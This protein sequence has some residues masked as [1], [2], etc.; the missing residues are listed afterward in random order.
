MLAH[1]SAAGIEV[2]APAKINL[3]LEVIARRQDGY[4]EIETVLAPISLYDTLV[5]R[6]VGR[7]ESG[8]SAITL[9]VNVAVGLKQTTPAGRDNLAVQAAE[10]LREQAGVTQGLEI[11]LIKRIPSEAGLGGASSD[12]AAVLIGA[13]R[14]WELGWSVD[15]LSQLAAQLGSD[16]PFFLTRGAAICRGRGESVEPLP[17][18][19]GWHLVIAHPPD[20]LATAQVYQQC[21]VPQQPQRVED[22]VKRSEDG[23][24]RPAWR[25]MHNRLE[26]AASELLPGIQS[27]KKEFHRLNFLAHQMTG[28]GSAYFGICRNARQARSLAE[29]LRSRLPGTVFQVRLDC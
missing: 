16:V 25:H 1:G 9:D 4:H 11:R 26:T 6:T 20:G 2:H 19:G 15:R 21:K 7:K 22:F 17:G 29:V 24:V 8:E 5:M 28:S 10:L 13:N 23:R 12:A 3:F 18:L 27:M 14:C